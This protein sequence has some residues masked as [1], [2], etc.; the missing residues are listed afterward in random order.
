MSWLGSDRMKISNIIISNSVDQRDP[1]SQMTCRTMQH[2]PSGK[3]SIKLIDAVVVYQ[4]TFNEPTVL[5]TFTQ[6]STLLLSLQTLLPVPVCYPSLYALRQSFEHSVIHGLLP[7]IHRL[8]GVLNY[9][10]LLATLMR[11]WYPV[12]RVLG[13]SCIHPQIGLIGP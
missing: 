13:R 10:C 5:S 7:V 3:R 4:D 1:S 12:R 11:N 6:V 9:L 8:I 2:V